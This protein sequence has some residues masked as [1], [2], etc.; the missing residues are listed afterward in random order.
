LRDAKI[1]E[2]KSVLEVRAILA[3]F[4]LSLT[5]SSDEE[6]AQKVIS[7]FEVVPLLL[8]LRALSPLYGLAEGL[9]EAIHSAPPPGKSLRVDPSSPA[10]AWL[11][12]DDQ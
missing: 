6:R 4:H 2:W 8:G 11:C 9:R 10:G 12:R 3:T 7:R 1:F 5:L